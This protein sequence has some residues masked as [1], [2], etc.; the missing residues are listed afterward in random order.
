M[1]HQYILNYNEKTQSI[2]PVTVLNNTQYPSTTFTINSVKA[3]KGKSLSAFYKSD[4][5]TVVMWNRETNDL[6]TE[7]VNRVDCDES[8]IEAFLEINFPG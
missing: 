5:F 3:N 7:V 6:T 4:K 8:L 2:N 1:L